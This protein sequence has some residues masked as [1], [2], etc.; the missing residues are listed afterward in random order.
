LAQDSAVRRVAADAAIP[1]LTGIRALAAIPALTG[2]RAFA[3]I[4]VVL[5]HLRLGAA[6]ALA[7]PDAVDRFVRSG[8][9]GV[10]LFGFLSGFLIAHNY[11]ERLARDRRAGLAP[12]L[13]TRAVRIVPLH[14]LV[15]AAMVA[16]VA[17]LPG[18]PARPAERVLYRASALPLQVLLLHGWSLG[19]G[20][21]WNLPSWTVSSEW[22]CYLLFPWIAPAL[23]RVRDPV[24]SLAGAAIA[25]AA[26]TAAMFALHQSDWDAAMRGGVVRIAGEFATGCLLQRAYAAGVRHRAPW[27]VIGPVAV[28]AALAAVLAGVQTGAVLAFAVLVL[29]LAND[30][31][32]LARFLSTRPLVFLGDAS[33][34]IYLVHWF[35]LSLLALWLPAA[36]AMPRTPA[37]GAVSIAVHVG[38]VLACALAIHVVF[39]APV[40]RRLRRLVGRR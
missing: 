37:D 29:A 5:L 33:Y 40:R 3:A 1:E 2:V 8:H 4:W 16:A 26:T 12:F 10:D 22:L 28:G 38:A 39:D 23:A 30:D 9:L 24:S 36:L 13:W 7:L 31:G 15:L 18:F 19:N 14:W 17:F 35:V 11:A 25:F 32:R 21:A 27:G 6:R 34:A 20:F